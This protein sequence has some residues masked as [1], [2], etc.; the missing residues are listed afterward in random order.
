ME[1]LELQTLKWRSEISNEEVHLVWGFFC[2]RALLSSKDSMELVNAGN[3]PL[4]LKLS[5]LLPEGEETVPELEL[6][7]RHYA[8]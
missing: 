5:D 3:L 6:P 2:F 4:M 8:F 1:E 7:V